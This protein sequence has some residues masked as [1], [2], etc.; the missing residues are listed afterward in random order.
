MATKTHLA[1]ILNPVEGS[2][3]LPP[4]LLLLPLRQNGYNMPLN[5]LQSTVD[6]QQEQIAVGAPRGQHDLDPVPSVSVRLRP[7]K[8]LCTVQ[9]LPTVS[10]PTTVDSCT[11]AA[12]SSESESSDVDSPETT[13]RALMALKKKPH[14]CHEKGCKSLA[15]SRQSCVRHG[16]GSRCTVN[17]CTNG[18]KLRNRCFQHGGSTTCLAAGCTSKAKRYGYCWSHGGGRICTAAGCNKVAAQ[19][20]SCWAHGGGNRCKVESCSKRSYRKYDYY[21]EVHA[22]AGCQA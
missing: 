14:L 13:T 11:S 12:T 19:G 6:W 15:V 16:G 1:F 10:S 18:A 22:A 7:C 5:S 8:R 9:L 2:A 17:G 4:P 20:G 21:C 3:P